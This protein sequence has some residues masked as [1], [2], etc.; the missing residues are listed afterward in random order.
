VR[1]GLLY[2]AY[3]DAGLRIFDLSEPAAPREVGYHAS[4]LA[5]GAHPHV[6]GIVYVADS[7]EGLLAFRYTG[8]A[9]AIEETDTTTE[10][11]GLVLAQNYPNP[12]NTSTAIN[13]SLP[14]PAVVDLAIFNLAGQKVSTLVSG[15]LNSGAHA[16][17]WDGR[18]DAGRSLASGVYLYRLD[19]GELRQHRKLLLI[20]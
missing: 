6:D 5:W 2:Y 18:D 17:S 14:G 19:A 11:D 20:K 1:D 4:A 3:Y 10:P 9:T 15:E 12:F 13:F 8:V 16:V 7:R